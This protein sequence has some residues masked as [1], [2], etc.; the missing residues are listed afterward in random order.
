MGDPSHHFVYL[1]SSDS[2]IFQL[3]SNHS[4][5]Y[6]ST[7][8]SYRHFFHLLQVIIELF[9]TILFPIALLSFFYMSFFDFF[10]FLSFSRILSTNYAL[11]KMDLELCLL[12]L[13]VIWWEVKLTYPLDLFDLLLLEI[14]IMRYFM[15][16]SVK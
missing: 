8:T 1:S 2:I 15:F 6:L 14:K 4:I 13:T 7:H 16:N 3:S 9:P 5:C 12:L 10:L 11:C